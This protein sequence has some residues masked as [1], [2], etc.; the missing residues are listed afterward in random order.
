MQRDFLNK[1]KA[2]TA[3]VVGLVALAT[4]VT[5]NAQ[6]VVRLGNL[7]FAHYGA[8]SYMKEVCPKYNIKLEE[9]VFAKGI[10]ILPAI[11]AG[12]SILL[13]VGLMALSLAGPKG[14]RST[15]L[16]VLQKAVSASLPR[17][18]AASRR[19]RT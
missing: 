15:S 2:F 9:K 12:R 18:I 3:G 7:K 1:T 19:Y 13:Q 4:A 14:C 10:D 8:V 16:R 5:A 11:A 6:D 17:R